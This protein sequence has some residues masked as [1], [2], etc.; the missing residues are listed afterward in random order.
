MTYKE[1]EEYLEKIQC[2]GSVPG[3][4]SIR[5]LCERLGTP[6]ASLKF[7][8][9]AGTNGKGSVLAFV[10]TILKTAGYRTGRYISPVISEYRERIQVNGHIISKADFCLCLERVKKA[11][12]SMAEAGLPHPTPF[13]IDTAMAFCYFQVKKCD[14]VVLETGMGG[15]LDATNIVENTLAAV[16][17]PISMDH[18][19]FLGKTI[20][21]IAENK[22][23][24]IK[25]G[26][27]V[28]SGPQTQD[29]QK[30]IAEKSLQTSCPL[31]W[32]EPEKISKVKYGIE[33]QRFTYGAYQDM[34]IGLAGKHQV[35]NA[36]LA[37]QVIDVL[38]LKGYPVSEMKLRRG[39]AETVWQGRFQVLAKKPLF[40]ADG[41]HNEGAA[42]KL[43]ESLRFY[44]TNRRIIYIMGI[45]R[46]KDY[47]KII[48]C[49]YKYA[50]QIITVT[51]PVPRGMPAYELAREV[52]KYHQSVT[53]ADSLEEAVELAELLADKDTVIVAFGSLSYLG[54]LIKIVEIHGGKHGRSEKNRGSSKTTFRRDR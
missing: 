26:C 23:G 1:A 38:A 44:F 28:I 5:E 52:Q 15:T 3:L 12:D 4:E 30:V 45:L 42:E 36:V 33:K 40:I 29:A 19:D 47:D 37:L 34:E 14:I 35:E 53:C 46:D 13:E 24:I 7:V 6:Q 27:T 25:R 17:T 21:R 32:A 9:I 2:Y 10:S 39:F 11:A 22:A 48:Q 18:P 43:A 54:A 49:T 20:T 8:H 51:P 41:A 16:I 50:Q 31:V